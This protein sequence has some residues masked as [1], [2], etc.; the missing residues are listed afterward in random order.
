MGGRC[1]KQGGRAHGG[2]A[3]DPAKVTGMSR[4]SVPDV[5]RWRDHTPV[6]VD[7]I[8]STGRTMARPLVICGAQASRAAVSQIH[9]VFSRQRGSGFG[10]CACRSR[11][12]TH[13][14]ASMMTD[15]HNRALR[16]I[17]AVRRFF[18]DVEAD[19]VQPRENQPVEPE[20]SR[21]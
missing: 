4:V 18:A 16:I 3:Q 8:V 2:A 11:R 5:E 10:G 19:G 14:A 12:L 17:R 15:T 7:D 20:L 13:R 1:R 9:A 6:L 21:Q